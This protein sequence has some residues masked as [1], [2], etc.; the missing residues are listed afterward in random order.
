MQLKEGDIR[1]SA[2]AGSELTQPGQ[3]LEAQILGYG[4]LQYL[5]GARWDDFPPEDLSTLPNLA[6]NLLQQNSQGG[7]MWVVRSKAAALL[8][9]VIKRSGP[10]FM[11][12]ALAQLVEQA[13]ASP[14]FQEAAC[15][16]LRY[17]LDDV[18]QFTEDLQAEALRQLLTNLTAI[19]VP[20]LQFVERT[21]ESNFAEIAGKSQ[22]E[23][24]PHVA[25]V[26]AALSV[27]ESYAE[28]APVS[29]LRE[30]GLVTAC[31]YLLRDPGFKTPACQVLFKLAERR[32]TANDNPEGFSAAM[33][34]TAEALIQ[35]A[36]GL[37]APESNPAKELDF[38][39]DNDEF[40]L[41]VCDA[42]AV[43]G[44]GHITQA[45]PDPA[46]RMAYLKCMLAF[47]QHPYLLLADKSLVL[48]AKLLQDAASLVSG[49]ATGPGAAPVSSESGAQGKDTS[50]REAPVPPEAVV[51]LMQLAA[52]HLQQRNPHV[53]QSE[54]DVP[55]YFDSFED[56]KEFM[57]GYR[58][59]LSNIVKA[60]AAVLP[61][62]ALESIT[63]R[64]NA[65]I[66][67]A[68]AATGPGPALDQARVLLESAVVFTS[69]ACKAVWD[70]AA[71]GTTEADR[72]ARTAAVVSATEPMLQSLLNLRVTD[73]AL[74]QSQAKG[75]EAFSRLIAARWDLLQGVVTRVFELLVGSIPLEPNGQV[76]PPGKPLPGW[77]EGLQARGEI[78]SKSFFLNLY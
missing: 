50:L 49:P 30:S 62:Q 13:Q 31:G 63:S 7:A 11:K 3:P 57:I 15:L 25:A 20:L 42:M 46:R 32:L 73:A 38:E 53:P 4:L 35:T 61:Q 5:V 47:A 6:Y 58:L 68:A 77:R 14:V 67:A 10:E 21:I 74:L 52:E 23:A 22:T 28:W 69:S 64:L 24:A 66:G 71:A 1:S 51:T 43:L 27:A 34:E 37:L 48:W 70:A 44:T 26:Q 56:Y 60:A 55:P 18:V 41:L 9:L 29:T 72:A 65:A 54:D 45:A 12:T 59:K 17:L 40:G 76:A 8:A 39:G 19:L 2:T 75:L 36:N 78:A 16:V 33:Q